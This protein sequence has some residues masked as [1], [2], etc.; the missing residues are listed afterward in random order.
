[1]ILH[2]IY[3]SGVPTAGWLYILW[4][5]QWTISPFVITS[6]VAHNILTIGNINN[7]LSVNSSQIVRPVVYLKPE[8]KITSGD[9]TIDNAYK[10]S[11]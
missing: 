5:T 9:G 6:N 4:T 1:M 7:S 11:L 2:L 10:L 3:A 8:V